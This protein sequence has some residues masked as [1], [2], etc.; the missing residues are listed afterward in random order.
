MGR[1]GGDSRFGLQMCPQAPEPTFDICRSQWADEHGGVVLCA[2]LR[3]GWMW[4]W[5]L[6]HAGTP[7]LPWGRWRRPR[8]LVVTKVEESAV[9]S[10]PR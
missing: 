6:G 2:M 1:K 8:S 7:L 9:S 5:D 10:D 3:G 4:M